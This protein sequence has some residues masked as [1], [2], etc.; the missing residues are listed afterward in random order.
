MANIELSTITTGTG[1]FVINGEVVNDRSGSSVSAAGDVN[2]DGLA[3]LIVGANFSDPNGNYS[4]RSYVVFGKSAGTAI[5][6]STVSNG[7]GGF[8][9]NGEVVND[10][11]GFSV[12]AAGDVN[13]DGLADLIV[14]APQSDPNGNYS[15]RSYVVFGKS[16][17]TAINL[18]AIA[19]GSGG[20]AINGGSASDNSGRSVS[21]AGDVNGDG[22]AD[23]IVGAWVSSGP[24][25]NVSGR[26]YVIFGST[27][28][29]FSQTAVDQMG[30]TD[31]NALSGT[32]AAETI[33]AHTGNDSITGN[34]GAD[35][36]Y[37]GAGD[38]S[39]T[40]NAD[41]IAKLSAGIRNGNYARIDGGSGIDSLKLDGSG[42]SF[43]LNAIANQ[44]GA[45]PL[46]SSRIES[47]EKIDLSG[48]GNNS[49]LFS[50]RDVIDMAG[51]NLFNDG[52]GWSG[53]D[54]TVHKHQ[55]VVD[56]NRGDIVDLSGWS[57]ANVISHAGNSYSVFN[58]SNAAQVLVNNSI[59]YN[60][61]FAA[62][63]TVTTKDKLNGTDE[64]DLLDGGVGA[65]TMKGGVS[66]DSYIVDNKGDKVSEA[67]N[68]GTDSVLAGI[69]LNW[70]NKSRI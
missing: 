35:V 57:L 7:S 49:L 36:I 45:T 64:N 46:S 51:C 2:G 43:D 25:G 38:D 62:D 53:L 8:V 26:S 56:G 34:S 3:D 27:T 19:N 60:L 10:Q 67:A 69:S 4:G 65:D 24:N 17:G 31:D 9:I 68:Q 29:A 14:G 41:N 22:L 55:L 66:D 6:L 40:L 54:T 30:N 52:N 12:S 59:L 16:S 44:S 58:T 21:A 28:G 13:G 5:N 33:V 15:G 32:S 23:L 63:R 1:G 50:V 18:S 39:I 42:I 37:A 11:S 20:F 70:A 61:V 47:I 48:S